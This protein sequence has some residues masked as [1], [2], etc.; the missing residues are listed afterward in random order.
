[1]LLEVPMRERK[2]A[3]RAIVCGG[4][5]YADKVTVWGWLQA[6]HLK[7]GIRTIIEGGATGADALAA[8][9]AIVEGV[10]VEQF[11]AEWKRHGRRAGPI[12]NQRMIDEG[13]PDIVIAFP[14]GRGTADMV[15]R[16]KAAGIPVREIAHRRPESDDK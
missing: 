7:R 5:D 2:E 15:W 3:V 9:W 6:I 16:A 1:M 12:R 13:K 10:P 14:G 11:P 4:R 8:S